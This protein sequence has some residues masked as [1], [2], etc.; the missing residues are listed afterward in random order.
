M[1]SKKKAQKQK[2]I[3]VLIKV[4]ADLYIEMD[5]NE[6]FNES[7]LHQVMHN[8]ALFT[9]FVS[10]LVGTPTNELIEDF[11]EWAE[12]NGFDTSIQVEEE[13]EYEL[14]EEDEEPQKLW[15]IDDILEDLESPENK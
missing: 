14:E 1:S 7:V 9:K 12:E 10:E 2:Q 6:S 15:S 13:V 4:I 5:S 11:E 8:K 3:D